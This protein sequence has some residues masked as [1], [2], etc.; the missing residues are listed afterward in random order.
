MDPI[1]IKHGLSIKNEQ[2]SECVLNG[3]LPV[4]NIKTISQSPNVFYKC[5]NVVDYVR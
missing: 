2:Q 1:S 5:D 4:D 3:L